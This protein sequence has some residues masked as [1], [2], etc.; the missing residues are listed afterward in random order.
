MK[1][2]KF[3]NSAALAGAGAFSDSDSDVD[4]YNDAAL[5]GAGNT[6]DSA[7]LNGAGEFYNSA[8]L[9]G[10]GLADIIRKLLKK[11]KRRKPPLILPPGPIFGPL[12]PG[13]RMAADRFIEG[14]TKA[15]VKGGFKMP[16]KSALDNA[17][18]TLTKL[19]KVGETL[20]GDVMKK[21][22]A[23]ERAR[24]Q[25]TGTKYEIAQ[26]IAM[27]YYMDAYRRKMDMYK[28][29]GD[30]T[31]CKKQQKKILELGRFVRGR[32]AVAKMYHWLRLWMRGGKTRKSMSQSAA[33]TCINDRKPYGVSGSLA[34][35]GKARK[36]R[37]V[38]RGTSAKEE[39]DDTSGGWRLP[40]PRPG[41]KR[42]YP[43]HL[44][45]RNKMPIEEL[46]D[47]RRTKKDLRSF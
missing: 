24:L 27:S 25:A 33:L 39:A 21:L 29:K 45:G 17:N 13:T 4:V 3:Y 9:E 11:K 6:Y 14:V 40:I 20:Y 46:L 16:P 47:S 32:P 37:K 44:F 1:R 43:P 18:P 22:S 10:A 31:K 5:A 2:G 36:T 23:S 8:A 26:A 7:A 34:W 41:G 38:K 30:E 35:L 42:R 12:N 19:A 15:A 28:A